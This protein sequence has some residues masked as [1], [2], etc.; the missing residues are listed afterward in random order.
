MATIMERLGEKEYELQINTEETKLLTV[1][2]A[3]NILPFIQQLVIFEV[4]D[5][6]EWRQL[7]RNHS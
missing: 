4:V 3:D 1:E 7:L 6:S 5:R 2:R